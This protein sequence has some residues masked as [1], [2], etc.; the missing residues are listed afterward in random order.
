MKRAFRCAAKSSSGFMLAGSGLF[1]IVPMPCWG[2][3]VV[4]HATR[5]GAEQTVLASAPASRRH[6]AIDDDTQR[7]PDPDRTSG[8]GMRWWHHRRRA[9]AGGVSQ[10]LGFPPWITYINAPRRFILPL[11]RCSLWKAGAGAAISLASLGDDPNG[12]GPGGEGLGRP[13]FSLAGTPIGAY[14]AGPS[15]SLGPCRAFLLQPCCSAPRA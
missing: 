11:R 6:R 12:G 4:W 9:G 8:L 15:D 14:F 10:F 13:R 2:V 3:Q 1:R 7:R 5:C